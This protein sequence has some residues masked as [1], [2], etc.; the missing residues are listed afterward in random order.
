[1]GPAVEGDAAAGALPAALLFQRMQVRSGMLTM[2]F[3]MMHSC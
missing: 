2:L 3:R 1:M